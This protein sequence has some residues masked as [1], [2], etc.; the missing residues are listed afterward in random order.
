[1]KLTWSPFCSFKFSWRHTIIKFICSQFQFNLHTESVST[2]IQNRII[3]WNL[4][5]LFIR[6]VLGH[7]CNLRILR[8]L[9]LQIA[10]LF[11]THSA[12]SLPAEFCSMCERHTF[13]SRLSTAYNGHIPYSTHSV[14]YRLEGNLCPCDKIPRGQGDGIATKLELTWSQLIPNAPSPSNPH[15][16]KRLFLPCIW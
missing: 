16:Y 4:P 9:P 5:R 12:F 3:C 14:L 7:V 10:E 1:M 2:L 6:Y 13:P 11:Y 15:L 8:H